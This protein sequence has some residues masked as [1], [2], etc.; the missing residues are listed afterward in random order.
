MQPC[1][2]HSPLSGPMCARYILRPI[3]QKSIWA[4][5]II[6]IVGVH[7]YFIRHRTR[8]GQ[9]LADLVTSGSIENLRSNRLEGADQII[10]NLI[11]IRTYYVHL[12][13][14]FSC[15]VTCSSKI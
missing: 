13:A 14:F 8:V 11:L 15:C 2:S 5:T 1:Q 10:H 9:T 12:A 6:S 7:S 3:S 4:A